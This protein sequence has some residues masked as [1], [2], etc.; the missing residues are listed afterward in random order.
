MWPTGKAADIQHYAL[1]FKTDL[2]TL[3]FAGE[4]LIDLTAKASTSSIEFNLSKNVNVTHLALHTSELKSTSSSELSLDS[5]SF[6]E[7]RERATIDL[8]K[9]G[10]QGL[11]AGADA[12]LWVRFEAELTGSM[13]GYYKSEGDA[14]EDG[15]KPVYV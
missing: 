3:R 14:G 2:K 10:G 9:A 6:D 5:L 13:A 12:K 8:K 7:E 1:A 4:A 11:R 15:K